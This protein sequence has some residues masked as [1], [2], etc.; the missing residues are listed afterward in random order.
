MRIVGV[1]NPVHLRT[2]MSHPCIVPS[3]AVNMPTLLY[4]ASMNG[5]QNIK[6]MI[7]KFI[8]KESV[9]TVAGSTYVY[10]KLRKP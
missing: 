5:S 3:L 2:T 9:E 6:R 7:C 4:E 8:M 1:V 10:G